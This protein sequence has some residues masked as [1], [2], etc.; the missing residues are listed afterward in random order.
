MSRTKCTAANANVDQ[1]GAIAVPYPRTGDGKDAATAPCNAVGACGAFVRPSSPHFDGKPDKPSA[2]FAPTPTTPRAAFLPPPSPAAFAADMSRPV[3]PE[4]CSCCQCCIAA[5]AAAEAAAAAEAG[6]PRVAPIECS[7][8]ESSAA[9]VASVPA[10]LTSHCRINVPPHVAVVEDT[11]SAI[12]TPAPPTSEAVAPAKAEAASCLK[13]A[14]AAMEPTAAQKAIEAARAPNADWLS[15]LSAIDI[16]L[17][18]HNFALELSAGDTG[19][20]KSGRKSALGRGGGAEASGSG[21]VPQRGT[22]GRHS[23]YDDEAWVESEPEDSEVDETV[24]LTA[25]RETLVQPHPRKRAKLA[26][27][28][29]VSTGS[30]AAAGGTSGGRRRRGPRLHNPED[31][32]DEEFVGGGRSAAGGGAGSGGG[33]GGARVQATGRRGPRGQS[34]FK[35]VC[36]TRAGKWRAVIYIGRKQ[37]YL[38]VFESELEAASAYDVAAVLHFGAG[39]KLNFAADAQMQAAIRPAGTG[40]RG[41]GA[42]D[43]AGANTRGGGGGDG[44]VRGAGGSVDGRTSDDDAESEDEE[45]GEARGSRAN[46]GA[47]RGGGRAN[48]DDDCDV[49]YDGADGRVVFGGG[50]DRHGGYTKHAKEDQMEDEDSLVFLGH[51]DGHGF[52]G[53]A[54][55]HDGGIPAFRTGGDSRAWPAAQDHRRFIETLRAAAPT[56]ASELKMGAPRRAARAPVPMPAASAAAPAFA[57]AA[58]HHHHH[59][60]HH[61]KEREGPPPPRA[62]AVQPGFFQVPPPP[63]SMSL[64]PRGCAQQYAA[65][66]A[67]RGWPCLY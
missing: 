48:D 24:A 27:G 35:G 60:H 20:V 41:G 57:A 51:G 47:S 55:D 9:P 18:A 16:E 2:M 30:V 22:R 58:S 53:D 10:Q 34:R 7:D 4:A 38:G 31:D 29:A 32:G 1:S 42:G 28:S 44:G 40:R 52:H 12:A 37:K 63:A 33:G 6:V 49:F 26:S 17:K 61:D 62:G 67:G 14:P 43:R 23:R 11:A 50:G 59:R 66:S 19:G 15:L 21:R 3:T 54:Y 8:G 13:V 25:A 65:A 36:I 39:A 64:S 56:A 5:R 46:S 45:M